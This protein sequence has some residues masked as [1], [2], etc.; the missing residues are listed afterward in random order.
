MMPDLRR[1]QQDILQYTGGKMGV[2]AVP[3]SGKTFTL[4]L[5]AADL[6]R[7]GKLADNQEILIVTLVN[8][9]V[10]NFSQRISQFTRSFG[11]PRNY[12]Y[13]VRTLHGLANDI[14]RERPELAGLPADFRIL[15]EGESTRILQDKVDAWR[16][17]HPEFVEYWTKP[18]VES[19]KAAEGWSRLLVTI[20]QDFISQAKDL[21]VNAQEVVDQTGH[22][23]SP[24]FQMTSNIYADY[25][26]ALHMR[27]AVDFDDLIRL[28]LR[29]L[30]TDPEYLSRLQ[31]RWPYVLEDEAQDSS[32]MQETILR[33]LSAGSGNWVRVGDP[34]Q[35]IYETFTT[36]DPKFLVNFLKEPD[37]I[38]RELP[39]SGRSARKIIRMANHLIEWVEEEHPV[40]SLR[41]TLVRPLI[42]PT[43]PGDPQPNPPDSANN[44]FID[45]RK[46]ESEDEKK[47]ICN[48]VKNWLENH[49]DE[50]A[51]ILVASNERGGE[52]SDLLRSMGVQP[53][54]MLKVS[55]STRKAAEF[56]SACFKFFQKPFAQHTLVDVYRLFHR[57]QNPDEMEH[58]TAKEKL[59]SRLILKCDPLEKY[60][61]PTPENNWLKSVE[62]AG[63]STEI[64]TELTIFQTLVNRWMQAILLPVD[65]LILTIAQD[66]FK[67]PAD[68]ALAQKL[69]AVMERTSRTNS[70]WGLKEFTAELDDISNNQKKLAGFS[71]EDL[72]FN[73]DLYK[74]KVLVTTVH[75][76]KGLEW[77][78]VYILAANNFDYPSLQESDQYVSEK[79]FLVNKINLPA[80]A[81][82]G[83][84]RFSAGDPLAFLSSPG[85][86][87]LEA[88]RK[89]CAERLRLL[90]VGI[91]RAKK[92][93]IITWNSG[94][95]GDQTLS[96][97]VAELSD[98]LKR[99]TNVATS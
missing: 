34:N 12:G 70:G 78:R 14:V 64:Q 68:L 63:L 44:I 37:V 77:D 92:E 89:Y 61:V 43:D 42:Q 98:F 82:D 31:Y 23:A 38:S 90:F 76:A 67:T 58:D 26:L 79:W 8:S 9:A 93:L 87:T 6:I 32:R 65:Q 22:T 45:T 99:E 17:G 66:V 47:K 91:T 39:N 21:G 30:Q 60:L 10:D 18:D 55:L 62:I 73:P 72:G 85:E 56:I 97:P 7:Q 5:L 54:E 25:Q 24:L 81:V 57:F 53:V 41:D 3:G 80:E 51:A 49:P 13:R 4:S 86:A 52:I 19:F 94:K 96:I 69:A 15:D 59:I 16:R 36:A 11:L 20:A 40:E 71:D 29:C 46:Y 2:S 28:A 48:N 84:Q 74:G 75:K 1:A 27:G 88:R 33:L 35:A 83:L 95:R 50:T